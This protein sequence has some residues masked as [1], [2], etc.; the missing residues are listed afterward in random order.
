M[1]WSTAL[2]VLILLSMHD[3]DWGDWLVVEREGMNVWDW[4]G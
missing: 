1:A 3:E 2:S 4:G